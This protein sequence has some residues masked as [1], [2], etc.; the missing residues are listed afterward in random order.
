MELKVINGVTYYK[1]YA[2]YPIRLTNGTWRIFDYVYIRY[3]RNHKSNALIMD[4]D[5]FMLD[6]AYHG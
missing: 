3:A 4:V 2:W 6:I 1:I 5:G